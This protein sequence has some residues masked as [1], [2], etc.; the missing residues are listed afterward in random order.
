MSTPHLEERWIEASGELAD[1]PRT[2]LS[3][4]DDILGGLEKF[5]RVFRP[6]KVD[7]L[8][9]VTGITLPHAESPKP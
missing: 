6:G 9:T 3:L 2:R 8:R 1:E 5:A 7:K 4:Q